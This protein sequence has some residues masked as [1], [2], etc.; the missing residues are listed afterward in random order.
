M[1]SYEH[2][3]KS[4]Y[5]RDFFLDY[6]QPCEKYGEFGNSHEDSVAKALSRLLRSLKQSQTM[7]MEAKLEVK[8]QFVSPTIIVR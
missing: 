5:D 2:F 4:E 7:Y 1:A 6:F 8:Y 3:L